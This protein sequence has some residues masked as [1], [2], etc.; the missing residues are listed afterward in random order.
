MALVFSIIIPVYNVEEYLQECLDSVLNQT[1][2]HWEAICVNDG[3]T[4]GSAAIL[5]T[6]AAKDGR[7]RVVTQPNKGLSSARNT[8]IKT[9]KGDYILFV[10]GDDWLELNALQILAQNLDNEDMLCFSGRR[11]FEETGVYHLADQL[12]EKK[13]ATGIEYYNESAL[14]YRDFAFVSVVLRLYRRFFL[15]ENSL[16]FKEGIYHEDNLFTPFACYYAKRVKVINACLYDY[17]VRPNSIM[18]ITNAKRLRDMLG[19][20]N[21]L[22]SFFVSKTGFDKVKIYRSITHHYQVVFMNATRKERKEL[23]RMCDW[24]LYRQ[25][26]RTKLRHRMNFWKNKFGL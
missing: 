19:I 17:R 24:D 25:V 2:A 22:A 4:D 7:L 6:Y 1:F 5:E 26:S 14:L 3:S 15:L 10:D 20:A 9:A 12:K 16:C 18:T 23:E 21:E 8:G 11:F 13:Y